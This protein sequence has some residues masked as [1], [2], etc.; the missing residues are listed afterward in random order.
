MEA[1]ITGSLGLGVGSLSLCIIDWK[2]LI[3]RTVG[4]SDEV[5]SF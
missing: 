2:L 3:T 5:H 1:M 4:T